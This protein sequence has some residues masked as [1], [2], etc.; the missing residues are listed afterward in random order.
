MMPIKWRYGEGFIGQYRMILSRSGIR[1][2]C[3]LSSAYIMVVLICMTACGG[4]GGSGDESKRYYSKYCN[5]GV[6]SEYHSV[7]IDPLR[8]GHEIQLYQYQGP[9]ICFRIS[10]RN[11]DGAIRDSIK[12]SSELGRLVELS[13]MC[14]TDAVEYVVS[15]YYQFLSMEIVSISGRR[16]K[17]VKIKLN[18]EECMVYVPN[19]DVLSDSAVRYIDKLEQRI[20]TRYDN[21]WF[22]YS[23][24]AG[25]VE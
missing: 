22:S 14:R 4:G 11:S 16:G 10:D 8:R 7:R 17:Y 12:D 13:G 18:D 2:F 1:S 21:H 23:C 6:V 20:I 25:G 24:A 3:H 5:G 19:N 15:M 9:R